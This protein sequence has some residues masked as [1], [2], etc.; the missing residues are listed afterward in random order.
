MVRLV[1]DINLDQPLEHMLALGRYQKFWD[2]YKD[3]VEQSFYNQTGLKF[4]QKK[5]T[6]K[7]IDKG[8]SRAGNSHSPMELSINKVIM[9]EA[10]ANLLHEL[11]H[12]LVIGN[13]IDTN[14]EDRAWVYHCHRYIDLFLY[15]VW[16]DVLGKKAA[17]KALSQERTNT[18]DYYRKA[19][20]WAM[21]MSFEERQ[22]K[23]KHLINKHT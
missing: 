10:G 11:A 2:E 16:V 1:F 22:Q 6:V 7:A 9:A 14:D 8:T 4:K 15:D 5:I 12:R 13:G 23:L 18:Y 21:S 17:D 3:K 20:D 19:W